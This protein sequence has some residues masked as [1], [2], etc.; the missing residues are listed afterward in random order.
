LIA[1]ESTNVYSPIFI[2][3]ISN[4]LNNNGACQQ[5]WMITFNQTGCPK[6]YS[7]IYTFEWQILLCANNSNNNENCTITSTSAQGSIELNYFINNCESNGLNIYVQTV[8]L[9]GKNETFDEY[10]T[11]DQISIGQRLYIEID[12]NLGDNNN[13]YD[14]FNASIYNIWLCALS[15]NSGSL[16]TYNQSTGIGGCLS[17]AV[18]IGPYQIVQNSFIN[19]NFAFGVE[20]LKK[21]SALNPRSSFLVPDFNTQNLYIHTEIKVDLI[22]NVRRLFNSFI[23]AD[24][25]HHVDILNYDIN[26]S[27]E[28]FKISFIQLYLVYFIAAFIIIF[29][30]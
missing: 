5:N 25:V 13:S 28:S 16:S 30:L 20:I 19:K 7:G 17:S 1:T 14:L 26:Y 4:C 24:Y 22:N 10:I 29:I 23:M 11:I 2:N 6:N 18:T 3:S 12:C 21:Q 9:F 8:S 15:N 27:S